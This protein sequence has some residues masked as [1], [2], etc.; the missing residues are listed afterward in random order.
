MHNLSTIE[1]L[2]NFGYN[3]LK[4]NGISNYKKECEWIILN[5]LQ[6]D[7]SWLILNRSYS[8]NTEDSEHF[9][10]C[11]NQRADHIPMQLIMGKATF[12]GRDFLIFPDVFIPRPDSELI[13]D[14]LKKKAFPQLLI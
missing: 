2:L 4:I 12:Y 13:I 9:L 5:I 3:H 11:I 8:M 10:H 1:S 7:S 6:Q 14:I